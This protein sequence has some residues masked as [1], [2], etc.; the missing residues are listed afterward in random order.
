MASISPLRRSSWSTSLQ[1]TL[2]SS[3]RVNGVRTETWRVSTTQGP[4]TT[5]S[6]FVAIR[7]KSLSV[8]IRVSLC[9]TPS[10]AM[11]AAT[12]VKGI[13]RRLCTGLLG[14]AK[15]KALRTCRRLR[16]C[17]GRGAYPRRPGHMSTL[18]RVASQGV[19]VRELIFEQARISKRST[20]WCI[21]TA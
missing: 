1:R 12:I 16:S 9:R 8:V 5:R 18:A 6:C 10:C 19:A 21:F 2:G 3:S 15:K 13:P 7:A 11:S 20:D 17:G 14:C 4:T